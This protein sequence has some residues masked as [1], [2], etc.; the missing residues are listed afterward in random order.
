MG[1]AGIRSSGSSALMERHPMGHWQGVPN[2]ASHMQQS[3]AP[4]LFPRFCQPAPAVPC[5]APRASW[6]PGVVMMGTLASSGAAWSII[7]CQSYRMPSA[8]R[9]GAAGVGRSAGTARCKSPAR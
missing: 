3:A 5:C 9:A 4:S 7:C 2:A 8:G 6:F 1:E